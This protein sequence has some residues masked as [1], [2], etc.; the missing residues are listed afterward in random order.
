MGV[1][2]TDF[3]FEKQH[4]P[5]MFAKN[6]IKN[7][8]VLT[9]STRSAGTVMWNRPIKTPEELKLKPFIEVSYPTGFLIPTRQSPNEGF[10]TR[11]LYPVYV[12][13]LLGFVTYFYQIF[14]CAGYFDKE[15][16]HSLAR[17]KAIDEANNNSHNGSGY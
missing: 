15:L 7:S 5:K 4:F 10:R 3:D 11:C 16:K 13:V 6:L 14:S 17:V 12:A 8:R 9:H 1:E 2:L